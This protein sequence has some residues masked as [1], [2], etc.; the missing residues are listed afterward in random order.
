METAFTIT[1][2]NVNDA[3]HVNGNG[4]TDRC[5]MPGG[6]TLVY[7]IVTSGSSAPFGD[8]DFA[9]DPLETLSFEQQEGSVWPEWISFD[10]ESNSIIGTVPAETALGAHTIAMSAT[11]RF[12]ETVHDS[13]DVQIVEFQEGASDEEAEA[14]LPDQ[15][16]DED[17]L[18][19]LV[20]PENT[21]ANAENLAW[22]TY[23]AVIVDEGGSTSDLPEWLDFNRIT[24]TFSGTPNN[25]DVGSMTVRVRGSDCSGA[26]IYDDFILTMNNVNDPPEGGGDGDGNGSDPE[27]SAPTPSIG[28]QFAEVS[29]LYSFILPEG[30]FQDDDPE[31]VLSYTAHGYEDGTWPSWLLFDGGTQT[32]SSSEVVPYLRYTSLIFSKS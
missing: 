29:Q 19:E 2:D 11:D 1:V 28:D 15:E 24:R 9:V 21:F 16:V 8:V 20:V 32:F 25:D 27:T 12:G 6:Q 31:D 7:E 4:L 18:F 3:P 5:A 10:P 14:P 17:T 23:S 26:N 13:F 22:L 30:T